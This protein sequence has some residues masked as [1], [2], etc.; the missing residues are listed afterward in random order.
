[1]LAPVLAIVVSGC[2]T[3]G[4]Y[5]Q[6]G[7]PAIAEHIRDLGSPLVLT[8][9]YARGDFVDSAMIDITLQPGVSD[10][11]AKEFLCTVAIPWAESSDPPAGLGID[12]WNSSSTRLVASDLDYR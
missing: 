8:V 9:Q 2:A 7:G 3:G 1:M 5:D 12:L 4:G 10:A 11:D 6:R